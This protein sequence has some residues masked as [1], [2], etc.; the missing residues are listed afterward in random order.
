MHI[1]IIPSCSGSMPSFFII[2]YNFI[3]M[4][5][6]IISLYMINFYNTWYISIVFEHIFYK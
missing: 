4:N 2:L 1:Y 6:I 5:Y 3:S